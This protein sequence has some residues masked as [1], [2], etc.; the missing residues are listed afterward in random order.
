MSRSAIRPVAASRIGT[1]LV[2]VS[3]TGSVVSKMT[4]EPRR[5]PGATDRAAASILV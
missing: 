1:Y 4:V 5:I 2:R 3:P